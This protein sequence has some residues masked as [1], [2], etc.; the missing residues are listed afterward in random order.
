[1]DFIYNTIQDIWKTWLELK[2]KLPWPFGQTPQEKEVHLDK[3]VA[4]EIARQ[5]AR[6]VGE[7]SSKKTNVTRPGNAHPKDAIK[8][9][10]GYV[11]N[12]PDIKTDGE[13]IQ[14]NLGSIK[15]EEEKSNDIET[16]MKALKELG[17]KKQERS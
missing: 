3:A 16:S 10:T 17:G 11:P 7:L 8:I 4:D 12:I 1:M 2:D 6:Q 5:V 14:T 9:K 13:E 15:S